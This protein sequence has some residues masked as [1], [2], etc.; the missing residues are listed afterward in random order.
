MLIFDTHLG[1]INDFIICYNRQKHSQFC[2]RVVVVGEQVMSYCRV[3]QIQNRQNGV[4]CNWLIHI[5]LTSSL[6]QIIYNLVVHK[7]HGF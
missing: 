5:E 6:D 2:W 7:L 4:S 1:I 3:S